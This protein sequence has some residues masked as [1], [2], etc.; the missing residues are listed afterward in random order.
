MRTVI[1]QWVEAA[2]DGN[3]PRVVT[4]LDGAWLFMGEAQF[5]PG[6]MLIV[7]DPVVTDLNALPLPA[8]DRLLRQVGLVGDALLEHTDAVRINYEILGNLQPALHVH[9]FPRYADEAEDLRT[10]PV[11]SYDWDAAPRFDP[12]RDK[13]LM[14]KVKSHLANVGLI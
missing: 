10:K 12:D 5:L 7:P 3:N 13:A 14:D 9:I 6:Y 4:K 2:R 8:R 11:W 1:H